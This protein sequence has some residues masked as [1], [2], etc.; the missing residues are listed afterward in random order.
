MFMFNA[1]EDID[2][3]RLIAINASII[4]QYLRANSERST[5]RTNSERKQKIAKD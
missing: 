2:I 4:V 1:L 5:G 3:Q